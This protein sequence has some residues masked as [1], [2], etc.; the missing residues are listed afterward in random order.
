MARYALIL[1]VI[2]LASCTDI[3]KYEKFYHFEDEQWLATDTA[4]FEIEIDDTNA[5]YNISLNLRHYNSYAFQNL[6]VQQTLITPSKNELVAK[7]NLSLGNKMGQWHGVALNDVVNVEIPTERKVMFSQAGKYQFK[8]V[9]L[10][11][12]H[13]LPDVLDFGITIEKNK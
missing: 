8:F 11:R 4:I 6:W 10:M 9:H 1:F 2:I 3:A 12:D 5:N 7:R 13:H